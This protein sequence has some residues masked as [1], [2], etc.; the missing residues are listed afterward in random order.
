MVANINPNEME[1]AMGIK[2]Y[3]CKEV[4]KSNGVKPAMVVNEVSKTARR[5]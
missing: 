2:N 3:A 1:T 5:R 4:S